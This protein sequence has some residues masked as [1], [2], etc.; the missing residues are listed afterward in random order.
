MISYVARD[1]NVGWTSESRHRIIES[2]RSDRSYSL[3][4]VCSHLCL[5]NAQDS[6]DSF[7]AAPDVCRRLLN[8]VRSERLR[9]D[10]VSKHVV[11][12]SLKSRGSLTRDT[13]MTERIWQQWV[14]SMHDC[15]A[16]HDAMHDITS[17]KASHCQSST[18]GVRRGKA[19]AWHARHEQMYRLVSSTWSISWQCLRFAASEGHDI[20]CEEPETVGSDIRR[21]LDSV[22]VRY[23]TIKGR[24]RVHTLTELKSGV[25]TVEQLCRSTLQSCSWVVQL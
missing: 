14:Y 16:I 4:Y 15:G 5:G 6:L 1:W 20:N 23:A 21:S 12:R 17:P 2:F 9:T 18:C 11:M 3:C 22:Y 24:H 8:C 10:I 13:Y 25:K 7:P 19:S